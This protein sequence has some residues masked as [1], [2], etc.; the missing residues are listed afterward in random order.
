MAQSSFSWHIQV[1]QSKN[2]QLSSHALVFAYDTR[3]KKSIRCFRPFTVPIA[4]GAK[5]LRN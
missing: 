2:D 5:W 3:A 4:G 1:D